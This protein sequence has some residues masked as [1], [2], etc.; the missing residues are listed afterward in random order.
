MEIIETNQITK[1]GF[2]IV[3]YHSKDH[4]QYTANTGN[5]SRIVKCA[6]IGRAHV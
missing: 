6:K 5:I 1:E 2:E 3:L 4:G